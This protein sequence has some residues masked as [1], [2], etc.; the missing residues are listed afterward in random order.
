M[1]SITT[2]LI[3]VASWR[4]YQ[5]MGYQGW[6]SIVPFYNVYVLFGELYGNG[7]R[8]LL[9]VCQVFCVS[10]IMEGE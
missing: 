9:R 7:W 4:V 5:K 6:E 8:F 3:L 1:I 2:V 10:K